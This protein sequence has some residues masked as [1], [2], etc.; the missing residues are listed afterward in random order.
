MTKL[1][2][3]DKGFFQYG[4][5]EQIAYNLDNIKNTAECYIVEGEIDALS[6]MEI[7][8]NNVISVPDGGRDKSMHWL[9]DYYEE[10]FA[11]KDMV[12]IC[13]DYDPTGKDL[14]SE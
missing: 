5:C 6:L 4:G 7:G 1:R 9:V 3:G 12:Y 10:Y 14:L 13:S 8:Y 2:S 11:Y